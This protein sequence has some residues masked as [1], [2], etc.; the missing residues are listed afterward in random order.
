[1]H[2]PVRRGLFFGRGDGIFRLMKRSSLTLLLLVV[3]SVA[4]GSII[5]DRPSA[6]SNGSD[7]FV[8]WET[9]DESSV[10]RFTVI[11]RAGTAGDFMEINS[12]GP[13]GNYSSY[14]YV[15][16][17]V[18]RMTGGIFQYRIRVYTTETTYAETEIVT[19]S[20][21]S[22]AA[23]RTWGSIKAMFR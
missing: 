7:I 6:L 16:R 5:K 14:E 23:R 17:S 15:D 10:L 1:M 12:L 13:K 21:V 11:R 3:V 2:K 8:R 4:F 20:H 19:V 22:S 18:F 9:E